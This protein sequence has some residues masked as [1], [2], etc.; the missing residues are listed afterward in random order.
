MNETGLDGRYAYAALVLMGL[1]FSLVVGSWRKRRRESAHTSL[2]M[3]F[4]VGGGMRAG[5]T[6]ASVVVIWLCP[7]ALTIACAM[8]YFF[9]VSGV[10]WFSLLGGVQM[11]L[12][13]MLAMTF[14]RYAPKA[15]SFPQYI[16]ERYSRTT[17]ATIAA[18]GCVG[19]IWLG[20]VCAIAASRALA[21]MCMP[22]PSRGMIAAL[23]GAM[24]YWMIATPGLRGS[25]LSHYA[26]LLLS[27]F[28]VVGLVM[29]FFMTYGDA[30]VYEQLA[31]K[32][33][34][35]EHLKLKIGEAM[36]YAVAIHLWN[37]GPLVVGQV[38]WQRV[39]ACKRRSVGL[40]FIGAAVCITGILMALGN[41]FGLGSLVNSPMPNDTPDVRSILDVAGKAL[42]TVSSVEFGLTG[43]I[44]L[45]A[46]LIATA[47]AGVSAA[48]LSAVSVF[49]T[50][51]YSV[52]I[53]PS[54]GEQEQRGATRKA[55]AAASF[56]LAAVS[57]AIVEF[58][59]PVGFIW[60]FQSVFLVSAVVPIAAALIF[61]RSSSASTL[62]G[63]VA[64]IASG[65]ATL[66]ILGRRY[67]A[68]M[69]AF[70][71]ES[72]GN[73]LLLPGVAMAGSAV[74]SLGVPMMFYGMNW[75]EAPVRLRK[76]AAVF[77][78]GAKTL[79]PQGRSS[80]ETGH[81]PQKMDEANQRAAYAAAA[82][83]LIATGAI[84]AILVLK[85]IELHE[86]AFSVWTILSVVWLT[87]AVSMLALSP[88]AAFLQ[89][90]PDES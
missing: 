26:Q 15:I 90:G 79:I 32:E 64:G 62:S 63:I 68:D 28:L 31:F 88:I 42:S 39:A 2:K 57:W 5:L 24:G 6:S 70:M 53:R 75:R 17:H 10:F 47:L 77:M 71:M 38:Y 76:L 9:G 74:V 50:D 60:I 4:T 86:A 46:F 49:I 12:F 58:H 55:I 72:P 41:C 51:I 13:A 67:G 61:S 54:A 37:M 89:P 20:V 80:V 66:I 73:L 43:A 44:V 33:A 69:P 18:L 85:P 7:P 27:G 82:F 56:L 78:G 65:A 8:G 16:K 83:A 48:L 1:F 19:S 14:K 40:A 29:F 36:T 45:S 81:D 34:S 21:N 35:R 3:F 87:I 52:Y 22:S 59:V 25:L 84:T 30:G 11:L 23:L